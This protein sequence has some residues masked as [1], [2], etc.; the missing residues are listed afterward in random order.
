MSNWPSSATTLN[1]LDSNLLAPWRDYLPNPDRDDSFFKM[2]DDLVGGFPGMTP[3][4]T[5]HQSLHAADRTLSHNLH[6][7]NCF[8]SITQALHEMHDQSRRPST[9]ALEVT[10]SCS[11]EVT[12]RGEMLLN[13]TCTEDSTLVMLFAALIAKYLSLYAAN[14]DLISSPS[15]TSLADMSDAPPTSRVTIGKY[16]MDVEDEERLRME[17]I[18]M[19]LQKLNTLL[20]K[21]RSKFASVDVG[22]E[23]HTYETMLDFLNTRLKEAMKKLQRQKQRYQS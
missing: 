2:S 11:K 7:C 20:V 22:Y 12:A 18:L 13:C 6:T 3:S 4:P 1:D 10:L 14:I 5:E 9:P 17:I 16:T 15:C 21:F 19:E 23:G 8:V